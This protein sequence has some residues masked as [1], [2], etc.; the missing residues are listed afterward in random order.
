MQHLY[1]KVTNLTFTPHTPLNS[2][3]IKDFDSHIHF[4]KNPKKYNLIQDNIVI[5]NQDQ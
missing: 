2:P 4:F 3:K 5:G 1:Q